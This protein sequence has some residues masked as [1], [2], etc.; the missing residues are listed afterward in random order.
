MRRINR[1]LYVGDPS[2]VTQPEKSLLQPHL[3]VGQTEKIETIKLNE[4]W[5]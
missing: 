4:P 1:L 5:R 3:L 2:W